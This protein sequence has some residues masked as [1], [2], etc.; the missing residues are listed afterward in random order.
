MPAEPDHPDCRHGEDQL[1]EGEHHCEHCADAE[2]NGLQGVVRAC[3]AVAELVLAHKCPDDPDAAEFFAQHSV[4]P[5][6]A[7]LLA[8]EER[9]EDDEGDR[10]D[11]GD[12][13]YE[14]DQEAG[15]LR[16]HA[17]RHH[18]AADAHD[19]CGN[20]EVEDHQN[21]HLDLLNVVGGP[22]D[23]RRCA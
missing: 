21:Y 8:A 11:D 18:D 10:Y 9:I 19:W 7:V 2:G 13:W 20:H 15:Q 12:Q 5:V 16:V 23:K 1:Q 17:E 4:H 22:G 3:V 14:D 6:E